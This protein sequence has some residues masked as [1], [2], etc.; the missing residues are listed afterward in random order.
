M[1]MNTWVCPAF[2]HETVLRD[3]AWFQGLVPKIDEFW[4]DVEKAKQGSFTIPESS[5]KKKEV[6]CEIVDSDHETESPKQAEP[7]Y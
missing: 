1:E 3:E 4:A 5:R 2:H 6:V 7:Q